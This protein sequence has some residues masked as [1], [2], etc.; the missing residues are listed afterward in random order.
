MLENLISAARGERQVD[1]LVRGGNV[2]NVLSGEI[3]ETDVAICDGRFVGFGDYEAE[4]VLDARGLTLCPG[5]IDAHVHVES[6][7]VTVP[8]FARAV[9]PHGTT[10]AFV[11]PHEVANVLGLE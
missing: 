4:E 2:I 7:M 9:V 1:L 3:H 11:D 8:E 6:S 10:T 5:L